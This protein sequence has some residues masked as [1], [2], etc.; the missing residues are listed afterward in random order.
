MGRKKGSKNKKKRETTK[1]T[2]KTFLSEFTG[3]LVFVL[4]LALIVLFKFDNIGAVADNINMLF[5]GLLGEARILF[6]IVCMY[7]GVVAIVS[8]KKKKVSAELLKGA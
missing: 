3:G 7:V 4:G 1:E 2:K 8:S 6:P 5:T